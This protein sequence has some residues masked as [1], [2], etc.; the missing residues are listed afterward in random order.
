MQTRLFLCLVL[1]AIGLHTL[2]AFR[3]AIKPGI[4]PNIVFI[5]AD[6]MG[7]GDLGCYG[8]QRISTPRL[9]QMAAE[10]MRFTQFYTGSTVCAPSRAT[11]MSGRHTGRTYIRGN[12]EVALRPQD[13][14]LP[15]QLKKAGYTTGLF[16]KWG[17]GPLGT[18]GEPP[19][20]GWDTFFG[21]LH[22]VAAHF[23]QPDTLW[24]AEA[25]DGRITP[26][27]QPK[28]AYA[29]EAFTEAAI[30]FIGKKRSQPF[31]LYLAFTLP[32]AGLQVPEQFTKAYQTTDGSS[33]FGPEKPYPDGQH[34]GA[35]P[36]PKVAYAAMVSSVDAYVGQVLDALAKQGLDE[37]TL[38]LFASDNGTHVEGGRSRA[39]VAY[40]QS[41]GPLRGIKRDLYE[42]G[43][44]TPF[45]A[46]WP[47]RIKP[48]QTSTFQGAFWD[49][50]PTFC[51]LAK[52]RPA[53]PTDGVSLLPT[54]LSTGRQQTHT[55]LYW[56]FYE[57]GFSQA[58]RQVN[59]KAIR[60]VGPTGTVTTELYD[61]SHDPSESTD[62][63]ARFP[64][65]V[66]ALQA[67][68]KQAHID[69][70]LPQFRAPTL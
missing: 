2:L 66:Q 41:S 65:R 6:D 16:G 26:V 46:R 53:A 38:V 13:L 7:Y 37:N 28:G 55:Y 57:A 43:I 47:G 51:S 14:I 21:Q 18:T 35:Q 12:G 20:Q 32:H 69:S 61:L 45:I 36:Q 60:R 1:L 62:L 56:E 50:V 30:R 39:D 34:Y 17:L 29:N 5:L 24:Q 54:L 33:R 8:Q 15:E 31:F 49:M 10:G 58:V 22:H 59:W 40:F 11:L 48:G 3:P 63:A 44:R 52:I 70:E 4:P 27:I 25:V 64:Q 23:Q 42:G 67:L 19:K 68:M 9:D